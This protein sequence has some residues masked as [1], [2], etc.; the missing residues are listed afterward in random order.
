MSKRIIIGINNDLVITPTSTDASC[1]LSN[2]NASIAVSGGIAAIDY[3]YSWVDNT[4]SVISTNNNISGVSA[5]IFVV[6]VTDD[7]N[8]SDTATYSVV[9]NNTL[10]M[11][12]NITPA[13]C[14]VA[15]GAASITISGGVVGPAGYQVIFSP[16]WL[17]SKVKGA[18]NEEFEPMKTLSLITVLCF[19]I[20]S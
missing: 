6:T 2:G 12:Q 14:G 19:L 17:A 11:T 4:N 15:N 9:E 7:V 3:Q 20:P 5:G 10:S 16:E 18:I 8:C 1:G 13:S